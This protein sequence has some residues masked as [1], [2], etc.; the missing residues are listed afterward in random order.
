M[1]AGIQATKSTISEA[2]KNVCKMLEYANSG[3]KETSLS[4]LISPASVRR[5]WEELDQYKKERTES[6]A[7]IAAVSGDVA[8]FLTVPYLVLSGRDMNQCNFSG[9]LASVLLVP[10]SCIIVT[11][12]NLTENGFSRLASI[13]RDLQAYFDSRLTVFIQ[14]EIDLPAS[15]SDNVEKIFETPLSRKRVLSGE[16][17]SK[18][19]KVD[20]KDTITI[21][22]HQE[23]VLAKNREIFESAKTIG[24]Q[25]DIFKVK[26]S[27]FETTLA[28]FEEKIN[29]QDT[30]INLL[31]EK[32]NSLVHEINEITE[33]LNNQRI[34]K[35]SAIKNLESRHLVEKSVLEDKIN[36][37]LKDICVQEDKINS[38]IKEK[39]LIE[40]KFNKELNEKDSVIESLKRKLQLKQTEIDH[41]EPRDNVEVSSKDKDK[42]AVEPSNTLS[43]STS[44][45]ESGKIEDVA[46]STA[47][48]LEHFTT[49]LKKYSENPKLSAK[50]IVFRSFRNIKVAVTVDVRSEDVYVCEL[51]I[52]KDASKLLENRV[53][54]ASG[55][56]RHKAMMA[57][58]SSILSYFNL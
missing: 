46:V 44:E 51:K 47:D 32:N 54:S 38:Q 3:K 17:V 42:E 26:E 34:E 23:I 9:N 58:Y 11:T 15:I 8:E 40:D 33:K 36:K 21:K 2:T 13:L 16:V 28:N 48:R 52:T 55:T 12:E 49:K 24:E 20:V 43:C 35:D 18:L 29:T 14:T 31:E 30:E 27:E 37:N 45:V 39:R 41:C 25:E 7:L 6:A 56:S 1:K 22:D 53:F 10:V 57:A 50:E 5:I 19:R 4:S